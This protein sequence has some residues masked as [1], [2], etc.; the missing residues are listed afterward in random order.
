MDLITDPVLT[1]PLPPRPIKVNYLYHHL[2]SGCAKPRELLSFI[3]KTS[4]KRHVDV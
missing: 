1:E 3:C 4:P 2:A